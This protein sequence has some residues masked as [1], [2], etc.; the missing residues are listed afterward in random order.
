MKH[1]KVYEAI[2]S[3]VDDVIENIKDSVIHVFDY[4]EGFEDIDECEFVTELAIIYRSN[5]IDDLYYDLENTE[6]NHNVS[7]LMFTSIYNK[8]VKES[9]EKILNALNKNPRLY[10]RWSKYLDS[11]DIDI[12]EQLIRYKDQIN[13][14]NMI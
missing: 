1:L 5:N 9:K 13:K 3:N 11:V 4:E 7:L 14:F 8:L 12:P 6:K 2:N 10:V